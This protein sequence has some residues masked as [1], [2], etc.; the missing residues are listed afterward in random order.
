M[1]I[2]TRNPSGHLEPGERQKRERTPFFPSIFVSPRVERERSMQLTRQRQYANLDYECNTYGARNVEMIDREVTKNEQIISGTFHVEETV[3]GN[4]RK[5][6]C[7]SRIFRG[8][9]EDLSL[10]LSRVEYRAK[11][12][13]CS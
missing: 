5:D 13:S 9:F 3:K 12:K 8:S 6:G 11:F 1:A 10:S 2:F 4:R 7:I